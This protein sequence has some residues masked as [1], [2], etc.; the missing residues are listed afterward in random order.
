L[1]TR[2]DKGIGLVGV[3]GILWHRRIR[4]GG[5]GQRVGGRGQ[6]KEKEEEEGKRRRMGW[7]GCRGESAGKRKI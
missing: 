7:A 3:D 2:R 4:E 1:E 5:G 6:G